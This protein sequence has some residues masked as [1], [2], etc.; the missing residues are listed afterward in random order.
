MCHKCFHREL[1]FFTVFI[2]HSPV[3]PTSEDK[4]SIT[5]TRSERSLYYRSK[6]IPVRQRDFSFQILH[7]LAKKIKPLFLTLF[8]IFT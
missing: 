1:D 8:A 4:S 7:K 3:L 6:V 5:L 2:P